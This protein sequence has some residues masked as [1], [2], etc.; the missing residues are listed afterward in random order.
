MK[1]ILWGSFFGEAFQIMIDSLCLSIWQEDIYSHHEQSILHAHEEI[2]CG[3]HMTRDDML[4][5]LMNDFWH[6]NKT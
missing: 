5:A 2:N 4:A 6:S 1:S 3:R